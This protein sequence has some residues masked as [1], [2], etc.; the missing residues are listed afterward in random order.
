MNLI[1]QIESLLPKTMSTDRWA[2]RREL[3]RLRRKPK[4]GNDSH[5][6]AQLK[7]LLQGATDAVE[8][9]EKRRSHLP[10]PSFPPELP[11]TTQKDI[12]VEAITRHPVV[13]IAGD[14]GS[15]KSTQIPKCCLEAGRGIDGL[16]GCT[17][18]RRIRG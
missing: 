17:Q 7:R 18:P 11:I 3:N 10:V 12:I 14:T 9:Q 15:G 16:I 1:K 5:T 8:K 4:R 13:I 2:L 6:A